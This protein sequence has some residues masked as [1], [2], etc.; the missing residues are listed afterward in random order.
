MSIYS[1]QSRQT[2]LGRYARVGPSILDYQSAIA[3]IGIIY[4]SAS[5][6]SGWEL[7]EVADND[8]VI[9]LESSSIPLGSHAFAIIGYTKLGFLVLNSSGIEWGGWSE[10]PSE[11]PL[12]PH[13]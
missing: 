10:T 9:Q 6:H 3:D 11:R 7:Q 2:I 4:A 5:I 13:G 12:P 8:G 1:K